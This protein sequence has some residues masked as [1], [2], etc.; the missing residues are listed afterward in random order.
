MG[1]L[2]GMV[3]LIAI[4][5]VPVA[6]GWWLARRLGR[7]WRRFA[8]AGGRRQAGARSSVE[9]YHRFE[10]IVA[11]LGLQRSPGQTPREFARA[12]GTRLAAVSGRAELYERAVQVAEAFYSVRFG[13]HALD[14]AAAQTVKDALEEFGSTLA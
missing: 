6:G 3:M 9:F 12:A 10:Q 4:L 7:L 8:G 5:I 2:L 14:A 1:W 13:R 11:R